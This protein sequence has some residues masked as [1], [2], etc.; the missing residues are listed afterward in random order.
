MTGPFIG[1]PEAPAAP[2]TLA[3]RR[4]PLG[5]SRALGSAA[6]VSLAFV[7]ANALAYAFTVLAART[8][9]P[10]AFG[11]LAALMS[12]LLVGSVPAA[13]VQTATALYLGGRRRRDGSDD[14]AVVAARLHTAAGAIGLAVAAVAA[15]LAAPVS[16]LLHLHGLAGALW[17]AGLL[18]PSTLVAG[19]QGLLQGAGRY[20]RLAGVNALFGVAKLAGGTAGLLAG[21][22]P[23]AALAGMS[24]A[25]CVTALAGWAASGRPGLAGGHHAAVRK[26][27]H[28]SAAL[29]GFVLLLNLDLLLARHHLPAGAAGEYAVGSIVTKVAFWLPQ[30]VGVVL[31]PR[32]ADDEHRRRLLPL[33]VG[34]V[35][36][37]GAALTLGTAALGDRALPL[38]GGSAYGSAL[39]SA[40]WLFAA[41]GTLLAIA[42]LLVYSG[43]ATSDR[44]AAGAVW[45]AAATE[46][47]VVELL[48]AS[49]RLTLVSIVLTAVAVAG[50]L[51]PVGFLRGRPVRSGGDGSA[52]RRARRRR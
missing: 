3:A 49:G 38:I 25:A 1:E 14:T 35:A 30:G 40:T 33:A 44:L 27:V 45:A 31:L 37:V 16:A 6:L 48:A 50:V 24:A 47:V 21:G 22:T 4:P 39:G 34:A 13:G 9:A 29:L 26:T 42:Q 2:Q 17:L 32:L 19:Y 36:V 51:V 43:I 11:E 41:L 5:S 10:A 46:C 8:L 18:V 52:G 28:A 23:T 15:L 12:V 20:G 7:G